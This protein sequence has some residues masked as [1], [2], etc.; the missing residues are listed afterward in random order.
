MAANFD[1]QKRLGAGY[2]GEVWLAVDTGLSTN[3]ALKLIPPDRVI[4]PNNF[5]REA[6]LLKAAE[7][8]NIVRV[9][10]TGVLQDGRIYIAMEFL[11]KGSL[12]DEARGAY[13]LL[14]R[15]KRIMIDV[16]R[17]LE[18]AHSKSIIHRDI[19]PAN[20]LIGD[21]LEGKLSDF[22]LAIAPNL[23]IGTGK[24]EY[25]NYVLHQ[26]PEIIFHPNFSIASDI[27]A[28]GVT[29][30]RLVNGD[31]YLVALPNDLLLDQIMKGK[32]PNRLKYREFIPRNLKAIINRALSIKPE[33]R[34]QTAKEMRHAL[35]KI[36]FFMNWQEQLFSNRIK[37]IGSWNHRCYE[38]E[39]GKLSSNRWYVKVSKGKSKQ[40][41]RQLTKH[42]YNEL[43][44]SNAEK[45]T[46]RILQDFVLGKIY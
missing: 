46:K 36:E 45:V 5:F 21:S 13:V 38:V 42:C 2:F 44:K 40:L 23:R 34:Y 9:E 16:L 29:L 30:Y 35:E 37:W 10:E 32:F 3:R 11:E 25:Y 4:D 17:G 22:G 18:Y 31:S 14:T 33:E 1:F 43:N 41:L 7:H 28:C 24:A 12:D 8:P 39:R 27:Y 6:Q 26:A 19:K 20:I 15:A